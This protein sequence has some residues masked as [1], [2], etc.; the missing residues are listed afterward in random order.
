[1]QHNSDFGREKLL[2]EVVDGTDSEELEV[3]A[4]QNS[5]KNVVQH[6]TM[7]VTTSQLLVD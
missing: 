6:K 7:F 1:L 3:G 2:K 5:L 4:D